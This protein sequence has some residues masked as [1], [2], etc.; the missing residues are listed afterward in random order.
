[1]LMENPL[2]QSKSGPSHEYEGKSFGLGDRGS[3]PGRGRDCFLFATAYRPALGTLFPGVK[4]PGRQADQ[5]P[6]P[7]A[8]I[9]NEWSCT[10]TP[11][12][13]FLAW[14]LVKHRTNFTHTHVYICIC[15][16]YIRSFA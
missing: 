10:F 1:M 9:K 15:F 2:A 3:I 4:R 14:D 16:L 6:P 8:D 13:V 5:S 11:S 12:Y 7:S